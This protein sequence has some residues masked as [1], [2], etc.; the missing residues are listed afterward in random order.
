MT[1]WPA[2]LALAAGYNLIIGGVSMLQPGASRDG[3]VIGLL[4]AE[5]R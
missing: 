2:I 3:R 4:V 1:S 5:L